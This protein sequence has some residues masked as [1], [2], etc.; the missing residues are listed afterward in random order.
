MGAASGSESLHVFRAT[1]GIRQSSVQTIPYSSIGLLES[2][3]TVLVLFFFSTAFQNETQGYATDAPRNS[4]LVMFSIQLLVYL[5]FLP[6]LIKSRKAVLRAS[7]R[8][9]LV[10]ALLLL[11]LL[12]AAWSGIPVDT[13]KHSVLLLVSTI[14]GIYFGVRF[15]LEQQLRFLIVV[16]GPSIV[17]SLVLGLLLPS[18]GVMQWGPVGAWR[19]VYFHR[20]TLASMMVL[21]SAVLW[22]RGR[23]YGVSLGVIAGLIGAAALVK[24]SGSTEGLLLLVLL[25]IF[26]FGNPVLRWPK[27]RLLAISAVAA[28]VAMLLIWWILQNWATVTTDILGKD[29]SLDG[30]LYLWVLAVVMGINRLWL[31]YG[32]SA[33]W[34][35]PAGPSASI[36]RA[37]NWPAP[38]GHNGFLDVFLEL[39]LVGLSIFLAQSVWILWKAVKMARGTRSL[40][41]LWPLTFLLFFF[42][43]N[44]AQSDLM[45]PNSISW[46]IFVAICA[47][48][49]QTPRTVR[50]AAHFAH[51]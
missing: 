29:P 21:A 51:E 44:L 12:S 34:L 33:F 37:L 45:K 13:L 39:G 23:I 41:E 27:S 2:A 1:R 40:E 24:L 25:V 6:F 20:N 28:P 43:N 7:K 11:S 42:I 46:A 36:W 16:L 10:W 9:Y 38:N 49:M 3:A 35:G 8:L 17:F 18:Y 4:N 14:F 32:Y 22:F 26:S 50:Q 48:L 5:A 31:G 19:G 47:F 30:R 15:R